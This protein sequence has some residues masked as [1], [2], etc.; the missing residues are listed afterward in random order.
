MSVAGHGAESTGIAEA[1]LA[2]SGPGDTT[3]TDTLGRYLYQIKVAVQRWLGTLGREHEAVIVCEYVDD[4]TTVTKD[5]IA[6]AQVKTRDRGAWSAAK[7]LANGGGID[8]LVRSYQHAHSAGFDNRVRLELILEG[9]ESDLADT[10]IFFRTP[11]LASATQRNSIRKLGLPDAD[12]DDF[13]GRLTIT[14]QYHA[15]QSIDGVTLQMLMGIAPVLPAAL[16]SIYEALLARVLAAHLGIAKLSIAGAP[17]VLRA[18]SD[19]SPEATYAG[20][21]LTRSELLTHL[22]PAPQ[23]AAEQRALLKAANGGALAM[24]DLEFKLLV[25]GANPATVARAKAKRATAAAVLA[26]RVGL[27]DIDD[28][29]VARLEDRVLEYADAVTADIAATAPGG[30]AGHRMADAIYGRFVQQ[31]AQLG[32]LDSDQIFAGEGRQVLGYLCE[33]SDQCKYPWRPR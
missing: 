9:M 32:A 14:A 30:M 11:S 3:G 13:L 23:L 1:L 10:R 16:L 26:A 4:I 8:A 28:Q 27:N 33:V 29:I 18:V 5:E 17:L 20:H 24:T 25:A 6:F 19:H 15:R 31:L 21:A 2:T 22:P 12:M 7:V